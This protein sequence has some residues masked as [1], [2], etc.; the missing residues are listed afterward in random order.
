MLLWLYHGIMEK[1]LLDKRPIQ[2]QL[3]EVQAHLTHTLTNLLYCSRY[4]SVCHEFYS[5]GE[6]HFVSLHISGVLNLVGV[7][8]VV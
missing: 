7:V 6:E 1:A 2:K 5:Q 8:F 3:E 4:S